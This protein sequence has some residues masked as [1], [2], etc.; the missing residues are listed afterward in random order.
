MPK[1]H[2]SQHVL[3]TAEFDESHLAAKR[4]QLT[5]QIVRRLVVRGTFVDNQVIHQVK[6][7]LDIVLSFEVAK[8]IK[9]VLEKFNNI[10]QES[11]IVFESS[12]FDDRKQTLKVENSIHQFKPRL[13]NAH[14]CKPHH[15]ICDIEAER[16]DESPY[17]QYPDYLWL[18][19]L[20]N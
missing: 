9:C 14:V 15:V 12:P 1:H 7:L 16:T 5:N 2:Y 4:Y 20:Q 10:L 17:G 6:L 13:D 19:F 11:N 18:S 3:K 8:G